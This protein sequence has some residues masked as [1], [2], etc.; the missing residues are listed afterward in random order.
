MSGAGCLPAGDAAA[1]SRACRD[2]A[3]QDGV[4]AGH[5]P[6]ERRRHLP[7]RR[8]DAGVPRPRGACSS[9]SATPRGSSSP[10]RSSTFSPT[11]SPTAPS[12]S[13]ARCSRSSSTSRR[14]PTSR[15]TA[16][17]ATARSGPTTS[18]SLRSRR[19]SSRSPAK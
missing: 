14:H 12:P 10:P 13:S 3:A 2:G 4:P 7:P 17:S 11:R 6:R 9:S 16:T 5:P 8:A 1:L 15:P 19:P 18:P